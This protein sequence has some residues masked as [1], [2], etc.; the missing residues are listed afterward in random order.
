ML[1]ITTAE[2]ALAAN[3]IGL[4]D[5]SK[6]PVTKRDALVNTLNQLT[7]EEENDISIRLIEALPDGRLGLSAPAAIHRLVAKQLKE[8]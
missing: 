2:H 5:I 8:K 3:Q 4:Y 6:M 7:K 1:E